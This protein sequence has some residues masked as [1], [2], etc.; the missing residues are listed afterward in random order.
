MLIS[1]IIPVY[2][3]EHYL[4]T[5]LDSI[6]CQGLDTDDFEIILVDDRSNDGSLLICR[7]YSSKYKNITLLEND[8]N[9]GP[10]LTRNKGMSLAR[11]EYI[12]FIDS[13]DYLFPDSIS[14]LLALNIITKSPD[15]ICFNSSDSVSYPK[16]HNQIIYEGAYDE[17]HFFSPNLCAWRYWFRRLFLI[18]NNIY[19]Q[20][21]K[22]GQDA[23][24]SFSVFSKNPYIII[25]STVVYSY[26]HNDESITSNKDISFVYCLFE[27]ADEI[28]KISASHNL[29]NLY[30]FEIYKNII[31]RFYRCRRTLQE[32]IEFKRRMNSFEQYEK[33]TERRWYLQFFRVPLLLYFYLLKKR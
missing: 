10:G 12:H 1:F 16:H 18:D 11:G 5:C 8:K 21:K 32:C 17:S 25:A 13:D 3:V 20:N 30:L 14:A 4:S 24:F 26:R 33:S 19:F 23:I 2:N 7:D 15:I 28:K 22:T 31:N 27:V 9:L 6:L 29:S